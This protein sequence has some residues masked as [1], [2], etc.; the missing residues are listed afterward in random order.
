MKIWFY[1]QNLDP[2]SKYHGKLTFYQ[3]PR[4]EY[5]SVRSFCTGRFGH[6]VEEEAD[7]NKTTGQYQMLVLP[8]ITVLA[9]KFGPFPKMN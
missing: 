1:P 4:I 9:E 6:M 7:F 8:Q 2:T 5:F 3:K